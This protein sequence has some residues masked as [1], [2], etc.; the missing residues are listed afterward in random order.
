MTVAI[1]T[2]RL[3]FVEQMIGK[4]EFHPRFSGDDL[5]DLAC[6]LGHLDIMDYIRRNVEHDPRRAFVSAC[7]YGYIDIAATFFSSG[8]N[9]IRRLPNDESWPNFDFAVSVLSGCARAK[10][11]QSVLDFLIENNL[12]NPRARDFWSVLGGGCATVPFLKHVLSIYEP[13]ENDMHNA[14]HNACRHGRVETLRFLLEWSAKHRSRLQNVLG[15][16]SLVGILKSFYYLGADENRSDVVGSIFERLNLNALDSKE[17]DMMLLFATISGNRKAVA[18]LIAHGKCNVNQ[19]EVAGFGPNAESFPLISRASDAVV[20]KLLLD[21]NAVVDNP[22]HESVFQEACGKLRVESVKLL[23]EAKADMNSVRPEF[24]ALELAIRAPCTDE[25]VEDK[26]AL[27]KLLI[28]A[29]AR[30]R[31]STLQQGTRFRR[32]R[33]HSTAL[34]YCM[35]A[36]DD[37]NRAATLKALLLH[38]PSLM[39]PYYQETPLL[40]ACK[41]VHRDPAVFRVLID[42]GDNVNAYNTSGYSVIVS[43]H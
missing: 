14:L 33:E 2:G 25:Q 11:I 38:D 31:H 32:H 7:K 13:T 41:A 26:T 10:D 39:Y 15:S 9:Y 18:A 43:L 8:D 19:C 34:G 20:V 36:G 37:S 40:L 21:A 22:R 3:S 4:M 23:L 6:K 1:N 16:K 27:I 35:D 28:E 42:A 24:G 30:T 12:V 29:G 5:Y 17:L